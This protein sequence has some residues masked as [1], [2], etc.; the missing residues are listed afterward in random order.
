VD[1]AGELRAEVVTL[2][3]Q[4]ATLTEVLIEARTGGIAQAA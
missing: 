3:A 1:E 2:T 4:V